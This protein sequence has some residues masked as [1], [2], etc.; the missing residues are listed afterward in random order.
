MGVAVGGTFVRGHTLD[1]NGV[2]KGFN[3]D[4]PR[5]GDPQGVQWQG[6]VLVAGSPV[7]LAAGCGWLCVGLG[8][9]GSVWERREP[10]TLKS[11]LANGRLLRA[12]FTA[13]GL[14]EACV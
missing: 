13:P 7:M 2:R 5:A 8:V 3:P 11:F 12:A 10:L 6:P 1:L 9:H 14:S 4:G